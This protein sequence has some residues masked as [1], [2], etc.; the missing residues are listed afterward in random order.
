M[1]IVQFKFVVLVLFIF[2]RIDSKMVEFPIKLKRLEKNKEKHSLRSRYLNTS[3][4]EN[5]ILLNIS[6]YLFF[7][8]T[9]IGTPPQ[10]INPILDTG[11]FNLIVGDANS[12]VPFQNQFNMLESSTF[13]NKG[14]S[15][16]QMYVSGTVK[17][18]YG[19][20]KVAIGNM[21]AVN[22]TFGLV[23]QAQFTSD[24]IIMDGIFG[25]G[26][27]Y[28]LNEIGPEQS[29]IQ[30]MKNNKVIDK[31]V[32]SI[33]Y[34]VTGL[35]PQS[36]LYVGDYHEDFKSTK[37][38]YNGFCNC[39]QDITHNM[40]WSCSMKYIL[41][42]DVAHDEFPSK[43][44]S[45][46]GNLI[47]DS[48]SN[49]CLMT[50]SAF[51]IFFEEFQPKG[52]REITDSSIKVIVCPSISSL[53]D[54]S[55]VV[56]GYALKISKELIWTPVVNSE[57]GTVEYLLLIYFYSGF[58]DYLLGTQFFADYHT[59]FDRE[60]QQ[61]HFYSYKGLIGNFTEYTKDDI[62]DWS[63]HH[64]LIALLV[65]VI[66]LLILILSIVYNL[67]CKSNNKSNQTE[68]LIPGENII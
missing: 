24:E 63:E 21:E 33:Q 34:L 5:S 62:W 64:H 13:I 25:F 55:F 56:N 12:K 36:T 53:S 67:K 2:S 51:S 15:F 35:T 20:D 46:K 54:I 38:S 47:F 14:I 9:S 39:V 32:F 59:L 6:E 58:A 61:I 60:K 40:Y 43:K 27:N 50:S 4:S 29:I 65:I 45:L 57:T 68:L 7:L 10:K 23:Q 3:L 49:V 22:F 66:L 48:G 16:V 11:S 19:E 52:C 1:N 44:I 17:G 37:T 31:E 28:S 8:E 41:F 18:I 30:Q 26:N 42:G